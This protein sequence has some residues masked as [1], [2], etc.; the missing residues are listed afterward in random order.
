MYASKTGANVILETSVT[1][2]FLLNNAM[3]FSSPACS[4]KK[5]HYMTGHEVILMCRMVR[6]WPKF[7]LFLPL[8]F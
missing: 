1:S 4:T 8:L 2:S 6:C 3:T 5:E 7:A